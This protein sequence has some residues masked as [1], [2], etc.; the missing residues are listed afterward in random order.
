[1]R[2]LGGEKNGKRCNFM[3]INIGSGSFAKNNLK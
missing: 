2:A 3:N 1:V